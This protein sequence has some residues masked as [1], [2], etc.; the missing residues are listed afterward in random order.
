MLC[1]TIS[2]Q[3]V[4]WMSVV[5]TH[6][7]AGKQRQQFWEVRTMPKFRDDAV[8]DTDADTEP[9][10]LQHSIVLLCHCASAATVRIST[11]EASAC[12]R[13]VHFRLEGIVPSGY[14]LLSTISANL[15]HMAV[16]HHMLPDPAIS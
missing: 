5:D 7:V 3:G 8:G 9:R 12:E 2:E 4:V 10:Y 16:G 15:G 13:H 14:G 6:T 1:H 11:C